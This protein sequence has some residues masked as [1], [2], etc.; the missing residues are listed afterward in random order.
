M[1]SGPRE[2]CAEEFSVHLQSGE[3]IGWSKPHDGLRLYVIYSGGERI[4]VLPWLGESPSRGEITNVA[5]PLSPVSQ[6]LVISWPPA[7]I[8][9]VDASTALPLPVYDLAYL[10]YGRTRHDRPLDVSI[11]THD[12]NIELPIVERIAPGPLQA[13]G[14]E[15]TRTDPAIQSEVQTIVG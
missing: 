2:F 4:R 14:C 5:F 1:L 10:L 11:I 8:G 9:D 7:L 15:P 13:R 3:R 12:R 6:R